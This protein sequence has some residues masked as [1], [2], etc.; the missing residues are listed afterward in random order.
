MATIL[1]VG[2]AQAV[3]QVNTLTPGAVAVNSSFSVTINGKSITYT[4]TV[5]TLADVVTGLV[6]ALTANGV[7]AEFTEITWANVASATI[8]ATAKTAGVPFT[9]T[10]S[11]TGGSTL[12][13]TATTASSGPADASVAA[14]Y[15]TGSMPVGGDDL[16]FQNTAKPCLYG[17]T[18]LNA[19]TLNSLNFAD[20]FTGTVGLPRTNSNGYPE[21][22]TQYLAVNATTVNFTQTAGSQNAAGS[23]R[24]KLNGT[25][26]TVYVNTTGNGAETGVPAVLFTGAVTTANVNKGSVGFAQFS[27]ETCTL[28][29]LR[30]GYVASKTSDANVRCGA[31]ATLTTITRNY[32]VLETNSSITTLSCGPGTHTHNSGNVTTINGNGGTL[33][34]K[35]FG[36]ITG[37]TGYDGFLLDFSQDQQARTVTNFTLNKGSGWNDPNFTVAYTNPLM[38]NCRIDDLKVRDFGI[39]RNIKVT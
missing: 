12:V 6:S 38:V 26:T 4:T 18:A 3:A 14:N 21:Y 16:Y 28:T 2:N 17:L 13:T 19:V 23:G 31:G 39:G 11:A 15:S 33:V 1:W 9:Q 27:G 32:G 30:M 34:W 24:I 5:G 20:T 22:R 25:F 29:T 10:S 35:S 36:T 7:P 8:T 37:G